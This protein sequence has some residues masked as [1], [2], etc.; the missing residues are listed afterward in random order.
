MR[1]PESKPYLV[2][3]RLIPENQESPIP[4]ISAAVTPEQYF[5]RRNHFPYP[6]ISEQSFKLSV[7]GEIL[8]PLVFSYQDLLRLPSKEIMVVLECSGNNR[9]HFAPKVFGEQWEG[10]AM[11]QGV[12]KGVAVRELL[13]WTGLQ[14]TAKEILFEGSDYGSRTDL[15][16]EFV[17]AR[18]LPLE[19]ALHP[20]TLIA[21]ALNGNP[22]PYKQGYPLRL[23]VPQWYAMASV[24]WLRSITVIRTPFNGP[25]Q[26][27][28]Y[29]YYP[30]KDSDA[31]KM[32]VTTI[33]VDSIIQQPIDW[34]V[35]EVGAHQ[36]YGLAWTGTGFITKVEIST[37]GGNH[38]E[39][40]A[41]QKDPG[42]PYRWITWTYTWAATQ[43]GE[44]T[45]M[46]RAADSL[47]FAQPAEAR[48]N[49]KGYGYNAY[50]T[51]RV[52]VE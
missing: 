12:W 41:I 35:L 30:E 36:I 7:G 13:K 33:H 26:A 44:Y 11:S 9:R 32:P 29:M 49:R 21:Y 8:R 5:Y 18:S 31:G 10:G 27:N 50:S 42:N 23:I 45:I 37:D 47:G 34:S 2:T 52:K 4:F 14:A 3:R 16:G 19:K 38:W 17:F 39:P 24:K 6:A 40:A 20:D 15:E 22:I 28:D 48:W 43:K 46:S 1:S 51:V 25:F